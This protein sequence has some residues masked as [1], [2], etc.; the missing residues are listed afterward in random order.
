MASADINTFF[1]FKGTKEE[2]KA[3]LNVVKYYSVDCKEQ[4]SHHQP[5]DEDCSYLDC[6]RISYVNSN[7]A[8]ESQDIDEWSE[9]K[10]ETI[11]DESNGTIS[12]NANGPYGVFDFISGIGI[13]EK[14]AEAAPGAYFEVAIEEDGSYED[15]TLKATLKDGIIYFEDYYKEYC[16]CDED[17]PYDRLYNLNYFDDFVV[18]KLPYLTFCD[19]AKITARKWFNELKYRQFINAANDKFG[20]EAFSYDEFK[21]LCKHS[22]LAEEEFPDFAKFLGDLKISET[23]FYDYIDEKADELESAPIDEEKIREKYTSRWKYDIKNH[24][25]MKWKK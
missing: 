11:L 2:L 21:R 18:K 7:S 24:Q 12:G 3:M 14:L 17:D 1:T 9:N 23:N 6:V 10:I 15:E 8:K 20:T 5:E 22:K 16:E 25:R 13:P 4:Y 19:M